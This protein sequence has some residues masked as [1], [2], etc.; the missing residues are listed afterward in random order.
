MQLL[1]LNALFYL[2]LYG[3]PDE[4]FGLNSMRSAILNGIFFLN[5]KFKNRYGK[6]VICKDSKNNWRKK[7]F[8]QYKAKRKENREADGKDWVTIFNYFETIVNE[9]KENLPFIVLEINELEADDLIALCSKNLKDNEE[10]IILSSDKD[11][12]QLL[13]LPNVKQWSLMKQEDVIYD[14]TKLKELIIKGDSSDGIPNIYSSDNV[15]LMEGV[16]QKSVTKQILEELDITSSDTVR[17]Y[18]NS[19]YD[20]LKPKDKD[21]PKEVYVNEIIKNY[22]RNNKLINFDFI[23]SEYLE[24]FKKAF[25]DAV[26]QSK[27]VGM[28]T[29]N[30]LTIHRLTSFYY[31]EYNNVKSGLE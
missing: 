30:Y 31:N 14:Q 8:E 25:L 28:K 11:M 20:T 1:D 9:I 13:K 17:E 27:T 23:P 2:K 29:R 21:L 3:I 24:I 19:Q 26:E 22:E 5:N 7:Y 16:R 18:F 12:M 6:M 4:E 15:F 10:H